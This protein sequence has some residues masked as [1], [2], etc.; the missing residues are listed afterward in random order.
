L[1]AATVFSQPPPNLEEPMRQIV[2][3]DPEFDT[4]IGWGT[5][6]STVL[7]TASI[8]HAAGTIFRLPASEVDHAVSRV[9]E[10]HQSIAVRVSVRR[11]SP[12]SLA[13]DD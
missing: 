12:G 5:G 2:Y 8:Y 6:Q 9:K 10:C 13:R 3:F 7:H 11:R 1:I 4:Q